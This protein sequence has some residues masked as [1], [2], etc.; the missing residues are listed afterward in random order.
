MALPRLFAISNTAQLA[1]LLGMSPGQLNH[2]V[3]G[4]D[5]QYH[6][7]SRRKPDDSIRKLGVPSKRLKELQRKILDVI[8]IKIPLLPCVYCREK[9]SGKSPIKNADLHANKEVVFK[10]D[11]AQCFPSIKPSRVK[12]IF[13]SLGFDPEVAGLLTKLTTWKDELPQG[14]P[15]SSALANLALAGVD[16]RITKLQAQHGFAYSRWVDDMTFS[17]GRRIRKLRRLFQRIVEDEGFTVKAEKTKTELA[18]ERQTVMNLVVNT[19]VNLPREKRSAIR[20]EAM[21]A[22]LSGQELS[23]SQTGKVY[24]LRSVNPQ[25]GV[26]LAKRVLGK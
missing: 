9:G 16:A 13:L 14:V 10:M 25:I 23:A 12:D 11:I 7:E 18:N 22:H 15:T 21:A 19:K 20:K 5:K 24:W 2:V 3:S 8:V 26:P 4:I 1:E 6:I 17:G